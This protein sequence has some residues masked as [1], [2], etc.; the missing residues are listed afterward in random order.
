MKFNYTSEKRKFIER[1]TTYIPENTDD[2]RYGWVEGIEHEA[3]YDF[4]KT[5]LPEKL[6]LL[7]LYAMEGMTQKEIGEGHFSLPFICTLTNEYSVI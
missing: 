7:T 2:T 5:M 1:F 3:I 4:L 6:E